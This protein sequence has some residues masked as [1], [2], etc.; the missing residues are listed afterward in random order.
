MTMCRS[1][2]RMKC[3]GICGKHWNFSDMRMTTSGARKMIQGPAACV[4]ARS[5]MLMQPSMRLSVQSRIR[6]TTHE[7]TRYPSPLDSLECLPAV[8]QALCHLGHGIGVGRNA[9]FEFDG[10]RKPIVPVAH[11]AQYRRDRSVPLAPG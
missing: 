11:P 3:P 10:G 9:V 5:G 2:R 4:I 1:M 6:T 8:V 7:H